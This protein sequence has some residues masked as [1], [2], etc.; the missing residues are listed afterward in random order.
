V[1][2]CVVGVVDVYIPSVL[3]IS[4]VVFSS[5]ASMYVSITVSAHCIVVHFSMLLLIFLSTAMM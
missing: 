3:S 5:I 4:L 1:W 2:V